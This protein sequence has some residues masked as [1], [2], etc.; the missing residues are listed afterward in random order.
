MGRLMRW[1]PMQSSC[2]KRGSP[3]RCS[4]QAGADPYARYGVRKITASRTEGGLCECNASNC[5]IAETLHVAAR[6]GNRQ[7][8]E[9]CKS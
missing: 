2:F 6:T 5:S 8:M 3:S 1:R 9:M 4:L 7:I